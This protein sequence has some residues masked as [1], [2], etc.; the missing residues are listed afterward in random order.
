M[1]GTISRG[2]KMIV[3]LLAID[4]HEKLVKKME[5][6]LTHDQSLDASMERALGWIAQNDRREMS[7]NFPDARDAAE[8]RRDSMEFVGDAV[9]PDDPPLAW[10][11][12]WGGKYANIYGGYVPES[13]KR[14]GYVMWD[15]SRWTDMGAKELVAMQ[16]ESAPG[17]VEQIQFDYSWSPV[18]HEST[19]CSH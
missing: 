5:R 3:R 6:C 18:E 1:D 12:L 4:D 14:W 2:L 9:P 15:A 7:T 13:I 19:N 16:W 11:L 8:Q 10:V 17:L